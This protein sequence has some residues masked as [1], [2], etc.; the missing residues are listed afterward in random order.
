VD[1]VGGPESMPRIGSGW[2]ILKENPCAAT[3]FNHPTT[4]MPR[5]RLALARVDGPG[6]NGSINRLER[7]RAT[8]PVVTY[9]AG[10]AIGR[11][12]LACRIHRHRHQVVDLDG[13]TATMLADVAVALQDLQPEALPLA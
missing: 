2:S 5:W 10:Y 9:A 4:P 7:P 11:V 3:F 1:P 12:K 13:C 6:T 8:T